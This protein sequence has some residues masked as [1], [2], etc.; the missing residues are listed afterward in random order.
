M[1]ASSIT[2]IDISGELLWQ[3]RFSDSATIIKKAQS[4]VRQAEKADYPRGIALAKLN[5]AAISFYR[6][7][8]KSA[9]KNITE[10]LRWLEKN[11][12]EKSYVRALLIKGNIHESFGDY[13][14]TVK[15]WH[16]ALKSSREIKD[17]E[18]EG[19]ACSQLGLLYSR[20]CNLPKSLEYYKLGLIIRQEEGDE[21]AVASS[22]NR[23]G[24]VYRQMK[25]YDESLDHYFKSLEIRRNNNQLSAIPWTMLGIASTFEDMKN[26][27]EA[28]KYYESGS[29]GGDKRCRLQCLMGAGRVCSRLGDEQKAEKLLKESLIM[30]KELKSLALIAEASSALS[31]HYELFKEPGKALKYFKL[32]EKVKDSFQSNA[33]QSRISNLEVSHAIE[34]SE[35]EKEIF[36][37][38]H[39]ELKEAFDT[40]ANKNEYITHS[41]NYASKIQRAILPSVNEISD[42]EKSIFILYLPNEIVSGDFY[43]VTSIKNKLFLVAA[44]CTGHGV[45]GALM[46][47]LGISFLEEIIKNRKI[48]NSAQILQELSRKVR[49]ALHQKGERNEAKDGMDISICIFDTKDKQLQYSGSHNNI[50]LVRKGSLQEYKADWIPIGFHDNPHEKFTVYTIKTAANDMVYLFSDGYADQF[51]GPDR[52]KFGY[53]AFKELLVKIS[54]KHLMDQKLILEEEFRKWKRDNPQTDD[55][56]VIG[57]RLPVTG[58]RREV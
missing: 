21:N 17:R 6:S 29:Q 39:I 54:N 56:M 45:P 9:L 4:L 20:L 43:W 23:L 18:C 15:F 36:R 33:V 46:S 58:V 8:N 42:L 51:G 22:L 48:S 2:R 16:E 12:H 38:R 35:Q 50:Y 41:I 26:Y 30:A 44:D 13:E 3:S 25:K 14:K 5:F 47:M 55:I 11:K 19:E 32:Y 27:P 53:S 57:Y 28:L 37:L 34:R 40:I 10:S 1:A 31:S 49:R 52:K 24:M 7:D